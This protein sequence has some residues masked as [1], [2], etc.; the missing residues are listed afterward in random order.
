MSIFVWSMIGIAIWHFT[1]LVPD[2][3]WGGIVGAFLAAWLGA[4]AS[5]VLLPEPGISTRNPPGV[6]EALWALPGSLVA[7]AGCYWYG[8]REARREQRQAE[9]G[10]APSTH[11]AESTR[12]AAP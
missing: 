1:V 4:L 10:E 12:S 11:G 3:F 9:R 8:A 7:L 5:G 2:R 6:D